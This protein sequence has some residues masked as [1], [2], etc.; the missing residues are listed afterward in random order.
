MS[1]ADFL[2]ILGKYGLEYF[3]KYYGMYEGIVQDNA[4]PEKLGRIKV[5]IPKITNNGISDWCH[6]RGLAAGKDRGMILLP[7]KGDSVWI[8]FENGDARY[9]IWEY[10]FGFKEGI[11][12]NYL[13]YGEGIALYNKGYRVDIKDTAVTISKDNVKINLT[14]DTVELNDGSTSVKVNNG[15]IDLGK[16]LLE[17]AVLGDKLD[18]L[19]GAL[20]DA[21]AASTVIVAGV[22]VPLTNAA[23]FTA[24]KTTLELLKSQTVKVS[25]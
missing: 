1:I 22:P 4:D 25:A 21:L 11:S 5:V 10:G 14:A 20:L 24:L 12:K 17:P 23:A 6:G 8:S 7:K 3:R 9:P 19:L 13:T 18:T 2:N 16:V 15:K